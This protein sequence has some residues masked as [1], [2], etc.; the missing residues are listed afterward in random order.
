MRDACGPPALRTELARSSG[1]ATG[2]S[3]VDFFAQVSKSLSPH[4]NRD[5]REH[6]REFQGVSVNE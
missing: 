6:L 2:T 4:V 5:H 3:D 1:T